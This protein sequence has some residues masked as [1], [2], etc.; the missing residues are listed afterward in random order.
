MLGCLLFTP[1]R[2]YTRA[3]EA[4]LGA[5]PGQHGFRLAPLSVGA[6]GGARF[7]GGGSGVGLHAGAALTWEAM[8]LGFAHLSVD[9]QEALAASDV[10]LCLGGLLASAHGGD[11]AAAEAFEAVGFAAMGRW[12][13]GDDGGDDGSGGGGGGDGG[14]GAAEM[15]DDEDEDEDEDAV[16]RYDEDDGLGPEAIYTFDALRPLGL[17]SG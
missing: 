10:A 15:K 14:E 1:A 2:R 16:F 7:G 17:E 8:Q 4:F 12:R 11:S 3:F 13:D 5:V 9:D 6:R